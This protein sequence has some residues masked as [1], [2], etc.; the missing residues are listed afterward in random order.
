MTMA[1]LLLGGFL[2]GVLGGLLGLGG[3]VVLMPVLRFGMGMAPGP[4]AGTCIVAVFFISLMGS[5]RHHG[6]GNVHLRSLMPI[7]V[8]GLVVSILLSI[9]FLS[10]ARREAWFDLGIGAIFLAVAVHMLRGSLPGRERPAARGEPH[11]MPG[12]LAGK[13]L[14]GAVAGALQGLF[15]I[16]SGSVMVPSF[17]LA[18]RA[19]VK[20]AVGSSLVCLT[21][22]ALVSA[23]FKAAQGFVDVKMAVPLCVGAVVGSDLGARL[24]RRVS[25]GMIQVFFSLVLLYVAFKFLFS[26]W[27]VLR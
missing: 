9:V 5:I 23:I 27:G 13:L 10:F 3:G 1:A 24:T 20:T 19:P 8:S 14:I 2:V 18:L 17:T 4:A 11:I 6:L 15:G 25:S 7:V 12:G 16:G 26:G 22:Y 21:V